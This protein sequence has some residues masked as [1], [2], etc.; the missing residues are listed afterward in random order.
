GGTLGLR[1]E[2]VMV[3]EAMASA[4][5]DAKPGPHVL[6]EVSDTGVGMTSDLLE[7][8]FDPFFTTKELGKGTGLGLSTSSA[9]VQNHGGF[10]TVESAPGE[11]S[12]FRVYL[13][14]LDEHPSGP[15]ETKAPVAARG[16]GTLVLVVDDE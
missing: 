16:E 3:E 9:I 13:P 14:A 5:P 11:G 12:T 10:L 4:H 1:L 15:R 2:D 7:R 6:V 8:I